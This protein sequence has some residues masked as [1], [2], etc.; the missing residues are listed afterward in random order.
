VTIIDDT[1]VRIEINGAEYEC[2]IISTAGQQLQVS[3]RQKSQM[4]FQLIKLTTNTCYLLERL[5]KYEDNLSSQTRFGFGN[6][7]KLFQTET[8]KFD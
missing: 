1:P 3:I 2:D 5:K 4:K 6:S 8:Q 7:D